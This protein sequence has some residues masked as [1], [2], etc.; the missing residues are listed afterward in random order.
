M[1][2]PFSPLSEFRES[3]E[4]QGELE[5]FLSTWAGE[6]FIN[7]MREYALKLDGTQAATG[8]DGAR[9]VVEQML[10]LTLGRQNAKRERHQEQKTTP[11]VPIG[12][13]KRLHRGPPPAP[14][15]RANPP[16]PIPP[17]LPPQP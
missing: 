5:K 13:Q 12:K 6:L 8:Q 15:S 7:A 11:E 10:E 4:A 16:A 3:T 9:A 1:A 17:F 14:A 2:V